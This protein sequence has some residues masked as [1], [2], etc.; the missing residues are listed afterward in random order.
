M[1]GFSKKVLKLAQARSAF[2]DSN[3]YNLSEAGIGQIIQGRAQ[4]F[5]FGFDLS[6]LCL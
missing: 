3:F 1:F 5:K 6:G 4:Q 2:L